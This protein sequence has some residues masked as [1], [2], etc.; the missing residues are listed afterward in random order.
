MDIHQKVQS[1]VSIEEN[2]DVN[3]IRYQGLQ[4]WPL[5]RLYLTQVLD[6][7]SQSNASERNVEF[8]LPPSQPTEPLL[9]FSE[10]QA[11]YLRHDEAW[12]QILTPFSL[13]PPTDIL[14]FSR[15]EN[16]SE[17]IHSKFFDRCLDPIQERCTSEFGYLKLE[18]DFPQGRKKT[19]R[20]HSTTFINPYSCLVKEHLLQKCWK[21]EN[22]ENIIDLQPIVKKITGCYIDES[23]L[24]SQI[25][26][27]HAYEVLFKDLLSVVRPKVVFLVCYYYIAAMALV[28]VCRELGI[29]TVEVQH[30][31]QG[32]FHSLY[33]HWTKIPQSGYDLLPQ[34]FWVWSEQ[35]HRDMME[36]RPQFGGNQT[37]HLPLVGGN[38]WLA[39]WSKD[40]LGLSQAEKNFLSQLQKYQ[41]VILVSLQTFDGLP[42]LL[43]LLVPAMQEA[44]GGWFWLIR[45][46]PLHQG[47]REVKR[48]LSALQPHGLTNFEIE[49]STKMPLYSLL[50]RCDY[51]IT[52]SSTVCHEAYA[53]GVK[54]GILDPFR[55]FGYFY[56]KEQI[57]SGKF[58]LLTRSENIIP[59]ANSDTKTI[60]FT[61]N[62]GGE[63]YI[64]I[65]AELGEK[66][67]PQILRQPNLSF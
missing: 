60:N 49:F 26:L 27:L 55:K 51:H 35:C 50:K 31:I 2:F 13:I 46:H 44:A 17:T 41:K 12:R 43:D 10:I 37:H 58:D 20:Y 42:E 29:K 47:E 14:F 48:V 52:Q 7:L 8:K 39:K 67:L 15:Y 6:Q 18:L 4:I 30:G 61:A 28:K 62:T 1:I 59:A 34:F 66:V 45:F 64:D 57:K 5:I 33:A 56:Y 21:S 25:K 3:S 36:T 19:P 40:D 32:R 22:L 16:H 54:T 38:L 24:I 65:R 23:Q 11:E 53:L 63:G 9:S